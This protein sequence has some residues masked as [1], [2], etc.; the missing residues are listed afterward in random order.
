[1][2]SCSDFLL[3]V[4]L[5][6]KEVEMID[7]WTIYNPR[8]QFMDFPNFEMLDAKIVSVLNNIIQNCHFKKK[9]SLEE[10]KAQRRIDF[11]EEDRIPYMIYDYFRV[12]FMMPFLTKLIFAMNLR[13]DDIQEFDLKWDPILSSLTKIPLDDI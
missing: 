8:D 11:Y 10:Q 3:N 4:V 12:V 9:V 2:I 13:N 1:M 5:S 7:L 6:I